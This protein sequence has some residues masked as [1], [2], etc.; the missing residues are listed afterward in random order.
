MQ[1]LNIKLSDL[2]LPG[3]IPEK[4]QLIR[5]GGL[6][7]AVI[8]LLVAGKACHSKFKSSNAK[9]RFLK[10][11]LEQ[12]RA[13]IDHTS[14]LNP[15]KLKKDLEY[16]KERLE[17]PLQ[18]SATLEEL[19]KLSVEYGIHFKSVEPSNG[20]EQAF[21]GLVIEL[22][23]NFDSMGKFLGKLDDI[24]TALVRI[25]SFSLRTQKPPFPLGMHL[26]IELYRPEA[27]LVELNE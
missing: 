24:K 25:K 19:N 26:E 17:A 9:L 11:E 2:K 7:A 1:G 21:F 14:K 4:A 6:A 10:Q 20:E 27:E 12:A 18:I 3:K 13:L 8:F 15:D 23:G 16:L 22:E 5:W